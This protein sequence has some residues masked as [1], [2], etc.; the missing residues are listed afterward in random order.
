MSSGYETVMAAVLAR[1]QAAP[2]NWG[3]GVV[4][5]R[6][7]H[8]T[9]VPRKGAAAVHLIDGD[10]QPHAKQAALCI[11]RDMGFTLALFVRSDSGPSAAD[12]LRIEAMR[13]LSPDTA[14]YADGILLA[15]GRIRVDAE[16][17]DADAI[18]VEMEFAAS[19]PATEW[20][21]GLSS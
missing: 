11:Q 9:T 8:L 10:D 13:R 21:L 6:R 7:A 1:L 5:V 17:A 2:A 14:P 19:Y 16:L 20:T 18:R 4:D 3:L 12:P 15:P